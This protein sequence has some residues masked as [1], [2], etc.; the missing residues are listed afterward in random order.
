MG[1]SVRPSS[2]LLLLLLLVVLL[3]ARAAAAMCVFVRFAAQLMDPSSQ[4]RHHASCMHMHAS[5]RYII[6]ELY[7][8][9][10][11]A[12]HYTIVRLMVCKINQS[13]EH[14]PAGGVLLSDAFKA[15][16]RALFEN[17]CY[18]VTATGCYLT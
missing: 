2:S 13:T 8:L 5:N 3:V 7:F 11:R 6:A 9:P 16:F 18:L 17:A 15:T 12:A 14:D 1:P 4:Q 10:P